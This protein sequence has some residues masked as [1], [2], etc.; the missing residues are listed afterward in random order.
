MGCHARLDGGKSPLV[1]AHIHKARNGDGANGSGPPVL[2]FCWKDGAGLA[3]DGTMYVDACTEYMQDAAMMAST[4]GGLAKSTLAERY[5]AEVI[6]D[7]DTNPS[8]Y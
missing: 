5:V 3:S 2:N 6:Q 4:K 1:A 8:K 7:L